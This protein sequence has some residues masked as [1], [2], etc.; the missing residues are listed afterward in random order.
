[1]VRSS[2]SKPAEELVELPEDES[3]S[4]EDADYSGAE[5]LDSEEDDEEDEEGQE[6]VGVSEEDEDAEGDADEQATAA[7]N[8]YEVLG[9]PK[10]A[11]AS[12]IRKVYHKAALK[13][14][15]DKVP[16]DQ[17]AEADTKFKEIAFA[18][19][20]LSDEK[21]RKLY[22]STG[23]T[24]G[25]GSDI[26]WSEFM[27]NQYKVAINEDVI[28]NVKKEYVGS[29]EEREDVLRAYK[30]GK[31]NWVTI[32]EEVMLSVMLNPEDEKRFRGYI[33]EAIEKGDVKAF[34][35]Y[36]ESEADRSK[37]LKKAEKEAKEA[38]K[39]LKKMGVKQ[40]PSKMTEDELAVL[41][42]SRRPETFSK[43][44]DE[45]SEAL[46]RHYEEKYGTPKKKKKDRK[47]KSEVGAEPS[48]EEFLAAQE[49]IKQRKSGAK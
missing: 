46:A 25:E 39:I 19:G 32:F 36:N 45:S 6:A 8:P 4:E 30:K 31:G 1:M 34:K 7:K 21:K 27:A 13:H 5:P 9:V 43:L 11:S 10:D 44:D 15:P 24:D 47:R 42:R 16:Q 17:R 26:D 35:A 49:R 37:R 40:D 18:Y 41:I 33:D 29:D 14:H 2:R 23:R 22:D 12:Q 38:D 20:I 28:A 48:E 3:M